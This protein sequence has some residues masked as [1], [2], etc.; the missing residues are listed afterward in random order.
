MKKCSEPDCNYDCFSKGL[1]RMH[2]LI[3]Y[4]K[5]IKKSPYKIAKYSK[6]RK[7]QV[8]KYNYSIK[9]SNKSNQTC[10]FCNESILEAISNHHILGRDGDNLT[11]NRYVVPSHNNCHVFIWHSWSVKRMAMLPWWEG[12]LERLKALCPEEYEKTIYKFLK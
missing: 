11:D 12:Y 2:W 7:M 6:K 5:P 4:G 10:F 3:K 8:V 1:C 9:Q